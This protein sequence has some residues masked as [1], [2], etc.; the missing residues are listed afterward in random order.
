MRQ[1]PRLTKVQAAPAGG[2]VPGQRHYMKKSP[3]LQPGPP[4]GYVTAAG[5]AELLGVTRNTTYAVGYLAILPS[6]QDGPRKP[7]Y[8]RVADVR[9]VAEWLWARRGMIALGLWPPSEPMLPDGGLTAIQQWLVDDEYGTDCP[10]CGGRALHNP[11]ADDAPVW[12]E[13]DGVIAPE[14]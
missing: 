12:C 7:R 9:A 4:P 10:A 11:Y 5:V 3:L 14:E 13:R 2:V 1:H 8:F 6:W